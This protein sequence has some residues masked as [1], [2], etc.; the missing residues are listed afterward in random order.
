[1][2]NRLG[3][4]GNSYPNGSRTSEDEDLRHP[5]ISFLD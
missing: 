2:A 3:A 5:L 1:M 4:E